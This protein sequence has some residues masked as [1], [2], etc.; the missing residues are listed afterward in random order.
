MYPRPRPSLSKFLFVPLGIAAILLVSGAPM[1]ASRAFGC[2]TP[3]Q[4]TARDATPRCPLRPAATCKP[5]LA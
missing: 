5:F 4:M 3:R 2:E 1:A